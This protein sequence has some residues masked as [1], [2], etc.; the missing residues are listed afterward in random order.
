MI[1][2]AKITG[3]S[4]EFRTASSASA[5]ARKKRDC[6]YGVAPIAEKNRKRLA[7]ARSAARSRRSV[8]TPFSSSIEASSWSRMAAARCTTVSTPRRACR[9]DAGLDRSPSA[10]CTRTRS[11][12]RRRGSRTRQ[13]TCWR[14]ATSRRNSADPTLPVAPVSRITRPPPLEPVPLFLPGV[15]VVVVAVE[16]PEAHPVLAHHLDATQ[17]L[18]R[19]PEVALWHEQAQRRAVIGLE[20]LAVVGVR[21]QHVVVH[22]DIERQVGGVA[23]V[24]VGHHEPALR[25]QPRLL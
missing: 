1:D 6:E 23:T 9:N 16:L 21:D 18:G 19:L 7:P 13:R 5:L 24:R 20:R 10:I 22:H 25:P 11:E 17:E 8:A 12:P 4:G 15:R 2:G 3:S 14:S